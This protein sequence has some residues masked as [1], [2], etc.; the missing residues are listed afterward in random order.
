MAAA[1]Q[2]LVLVE[3]D[4]VD[5]QLLQHGVIKSDG[6]LAQTYLAHRAGEAGWVPNLGWS[7]PGG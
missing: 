5:H 7:G 4:E 6:R 2:L 1:V 3:V